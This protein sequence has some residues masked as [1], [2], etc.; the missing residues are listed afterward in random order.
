MPN[1]YSPAPSHSSPI[2]RSDK[3]LIDLLLG[4]EVELATL[5]DWTALAASGK[6]VVFERVVV[7]DR[8]TSP[9]LSPSTL[10]PPLPLSSLER[11]PAAAHACSLGTGEG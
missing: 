7:V 11:R 9:P 1:T 8:C 5:A 4:P 6:P 10:T 3:E 2:A